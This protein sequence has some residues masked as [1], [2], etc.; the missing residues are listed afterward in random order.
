M[1]RTGIVTSR[2]TTLRRVQ[3][4]RQPQTG[5]TEPFIYLDRT[6]LKSNSPRKTWQDSNYTNI[7]K[8]PV[9]KG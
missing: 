7:L 6:W 5:A 4:I 1:E 9:E 2:V 8:L 3:N